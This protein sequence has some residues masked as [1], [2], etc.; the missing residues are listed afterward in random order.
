[1]APEVLVIGTDDQVFAQRLDGLGVFLGGYSVPSPRTQ[2]RRNN[3]SDSGI[4]ADPSF[5]SGAFADRQKCDLAADRGDPVRQGDHRV[6]V[7]G[8]RVDDA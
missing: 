6:G 7:S 4:S 3:R 1:V 2:W 8:G 5:L